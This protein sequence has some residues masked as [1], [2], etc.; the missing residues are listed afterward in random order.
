M[1]RAGR[2]A[3]W[4]ACLLC[5]IGLMAQRLPAQADDAAKH[6]EYLAQIMDCSGCHTA[7]ALAGQPDIAG[8]PDDAQAPYLSVVMPE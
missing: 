6:G 7:G 5:A 8:G 1:R 4:L 3:I 2:L